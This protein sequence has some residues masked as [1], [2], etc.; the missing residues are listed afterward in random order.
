M[1]AER[2]KQIQKNIRENWGK[3]KP[4]K[5][6]PKNCF[7][8]YMFAICCTMPTEILL[9]SGTYISTINEKVAY[10]GAIGQFSGTDYKT[11]QQYKKALVNDLRVLG[12][13]AEEC[14]KDFIPD[15]HTL[16][17]AFFSNFKEGMPKVYEE[18]HFL[19]FVTSEKCWMGK[20]GFP[21]GLQKLGPGCDIKKINVTNQKLIGI[22]KLR[23]IQK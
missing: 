13:F 14:S 8:C 21:G 18:F 16:K 23:L 19:R 6:I 10:F 7:N 15:E 22:F 11:L 3:V 12:I 2:L 4:F 1:Q 5:K 20:D 17:I 9:S